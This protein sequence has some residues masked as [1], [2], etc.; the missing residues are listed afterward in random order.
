MDFFHL[1]VFKALVKV[2]PQLYIFHRNQ[3]YLIIKILFKK[4]FTEPTYIL[5]NLPIYRISIIKEWLLRSYISVIILI[6]INS[7][8]VSYYI[9]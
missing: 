4:K 7:L 8:R 3:N 6:F 2:A 5:S 9:F 1:L